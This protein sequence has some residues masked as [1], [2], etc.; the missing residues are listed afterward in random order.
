[1]MDDITTL[2]FIHKAK[3][4]HKSTYDYSVSRYEKSDIPLIIKCSRHGNFLQS[5]N[6]HLNGRGC[7]LCGT[8]RAKKKNSSDLKTFVSNAKTIHGDKYNYSNSNYINSK[9][10]INIICPIHGEFSQTP[11]KHLIGAGCRKCGRD[12]CRGK[13][14]KLKS[15]F[16][17]EASMK[18]RD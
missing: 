15:Q 2:K 1:M 10:P 14:V 9:T 6:S 3:K 13:S 4:I 8:E 16:I 5:P 7:P 12:I 11:I 18:S 17:E